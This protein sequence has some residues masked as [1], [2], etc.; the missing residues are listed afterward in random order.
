MASS[1]AILQAKEFEQL[2]LHLFSRVFPQLSPSNTLSPKGHIDA[3]KKQTNQPTQTTIQKNPSSVMESPEPKDMTSPASDTHRVIR[4]I[5]TA[6]PANIST[7]HVITVKLS[8]KPIGN[9]QPSK[10][11]YTDLASIEKRK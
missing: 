3:L 6:Y 9:F 4:P 8:L 5:T 10:K 2:N 1:S 11:M 7:K